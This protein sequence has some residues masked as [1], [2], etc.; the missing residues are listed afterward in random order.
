MP[1]IQAPMAG[2]SDLP[3]RL[4]AREF[5]C[6]LAFTEMV[7]ARALGLKNRKTLRLLASTPA[8]RPLGI[9]LLAREPEHL[10]EGLSALEGYPCDVIDLNAACPVKKVTRKGEGAALLKEPEVLQ[11]LVATL[12]A[13]S[14]VAVTVKI[15]AGWDR[16]TI[17]ATEVAK[18]IADA[19]AHAVCVHGRTKN[20]GYS[21]RSDLTVIAE[22]KKAVSIPVIASGDIFSAQAVVRTMEETGCDAVMVARGG[23]G[24]PWI[25][26]ETAALLRKE[27][28][29][30]RPDL[31]EL[32]SVMTRHLAM[33][34]DHLGGRL[35][36][37][38]F[39]KFF[40]WYSKGLPKA[41]ALRPRAV[42][43]GTMDEMTALIDE[44]QTALS[45]DSPL[46]ASPG[47]LNGPHP[48]STPA[49]NP[50]WLHGDR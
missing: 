7:N 44:L 46:E 19:G 36:V 13:R 21:G 24:N 34:V 45:P 33:S 1:V 25:F 38:N 14:C 26:K 3:F 18:R 10:L 5:G 6:P 8:D 20:Q 16:Q 15:R 12:V 17:N 42:L 9:Q 28:R 41:R 22:V 39:R 48:G 31:D 23:L 27:A 50:G 35:G 11:R 29:P 37:I 49:P 4:I 40:A 43:M 47:P 32:R 30:E 2:I